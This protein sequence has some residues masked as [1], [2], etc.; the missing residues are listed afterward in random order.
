MIG[1]ALLLALREIRRNMLR[2]VLT[3]LGIV[4]GVGA[5]IALVTLGNG[6]SASVTSSIAS[7]G[8][9]LVILQH[10]A[11]RGFGGAGGAATGA[12]AFAVEDAEAIVREVANVRAVA[13]VAVRTESAVAGNQNHST[14]VMGT[15]NAY[16]IARDWSVAQG[17]LFLDAE[18]RAGRTVCIIGQTLR[19]SLFG[20]QNPLGTDI[21]VG[22]APWEVIG[23]LEP[24]GQST[25][26]PD[27]DDTGVMPIRAMQRRIT[28]NSNVGMVWIA[29]ARTEDVPK[30]IGDVTQLMRERRHLTPAAP[31]AFQAN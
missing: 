10:G 2:A 30:I 15:D 29:G 8:R 16:F 18:V 4:I 20:A 21:R 13:P 3:T 5:V 11:R 26:G 14:Q 31:A 9:N 12:P 24:K 17:R 23:V 28:G 27:Q 22:S 1:N 25:F 7:L 6:A 19:A